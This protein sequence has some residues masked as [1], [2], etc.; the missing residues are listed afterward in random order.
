VD[1]WKIHLS[2]CLQFQL[3]PFLGRF[4][5]VLGSVA[6]LCMRRTS[7]IRLLRCRFLGRSPSSACGGHHRFACRGFQFLGWSPA[8]SWDGRPPVLGMVTRQFLGWSP[9]ARLEERH[10]AAAACEGRPPVFGSGR[11]PVLGLVARQ[12][13]GWSPA[14]SWVGCPPVLGL[15]ALATGIFI[16]SLSCLGVCCEIGRPPVLG[17]AVRQVSGW[18]PPG[19]IPGATFP[20]EFFEGFA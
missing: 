20:L 9:T 4:L 14:S 15:V 13:S 6:H 2:R 1:L 18:L 17:L 11:P 19:S 10:T 12:F 16:L 3:L 7:P 8:S 5:P